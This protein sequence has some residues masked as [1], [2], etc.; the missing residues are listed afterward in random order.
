MRHRAPEPLRYDRCRGG[1]RG[2]TSRRTALFRALGM[3]LGVSVTSSGSLGCGA[4]PPEEEVRGPAED[5]KDSE[6][7]DGDSLGDGSCSLAGLWAVRQTTYVQALVETVTA[8]WYFIELAQDGE[9]LEVVDHFD[10]G[11]A[12]I[13]VGGTGMSSPATDVALAAHNL[14]KGRRGIMRKNGAFC[15]FSLER[16][17]AVRGASE[18]V[19]LPG[20]HFDDR[21]LEEVQAEAPLPTRENIQ[22][23]EDWDGD[24]NPGVTFLIGSKDARYSVS[25]EFTEWF[26]CNG[27]SG[28]SPVC[29]EADVEKYALPASASKE[30]VEFRVNFNNEDSPLGAT[31]ELYAVVGMPLR[32]ADNRVTWKR[33][34]E[35]RDDAL[36]SQL[37]SSDDVHDRC[38]FIRTQLPAE[39]K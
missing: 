30:Q 3:C 16:F 34:G 4:E 12:S 21:E 6:G 23:Q 29:S 19:Y 31:S 32:L 17:W 11:Y 36:A 25:R 1:S 28:D 22:G 9:Q 27:T 20:G 18:D 39:R 5:F 2:M 8:N 15:D 7:G 14:Q 13:S 26:S 24:G 33:L 38:A 10:C 37:F 35:S